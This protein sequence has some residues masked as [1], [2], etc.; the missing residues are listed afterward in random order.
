MIDE[1]GY[2]AIA[3]GYTGTPTDLPA[4]QTAAQ[5]L[6]ELFA[7]HANRAISEIQFRHQGSLPG[8]LRN[9]SLHSNCL[10]RG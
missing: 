6:H 8:N 9:P 3:L 10:S 1:A 7:G 2:R 4:L 5:D